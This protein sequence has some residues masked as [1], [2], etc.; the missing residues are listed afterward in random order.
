MK[1]EEILSSLVVPV[2]F[3]LAGL[4]AFLT[5]RNSWNFELSALLI[6]LFTLI[7]IRIFEEV[8]PLKKH[9][10]VSKKEMVTDLKHLFIS[11]LIFDA[12][13]KALAVALM[14]F[15]QDRFFGVF[16]FWDSLPFLMSF[17]IAN[18]V[19]ELFPYLY[20]RVSHKGNQHY[21]L[22]L[23]LWKIHS[24]HHL[25]VSLNWFKTNRIH[26]VNIFLNTFLKFFPL[27]LLGFSE[28]IV[29]LTGVLHVVVAYLSHANILTKTGWLDYVVVTPQVH[30]FHHSTKLEEAK[31]FGNILPVWDLVFGTYYNAKRTV[32]NVGISPEDHFSYPDS[33]RFE[34]QL[35]YPFHG[36]G[37]A[38]CNPKS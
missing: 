28:E 21:F 11:T 37:K 18:L 6:F 24:I 5:V 29:F 33:E 13:G 35:I 2:L 9:W 1:K 14:L 27:L 23:L 19:G 20:H 32:E 3:A 15:I 17:V 25:P 4:A 38:C 31:N 26:P 12:V 36:T 7:Y 10:K 22:S 8:N 34:Q 16:G 30:Q